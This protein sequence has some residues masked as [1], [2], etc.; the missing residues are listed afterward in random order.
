MR[1]T[2][3]KIESN[4]ISISYDTQG[5]WKKYFTNEKEFWIEYKTNISDTPKSVAVIPLLG[6]VITFSWLFDGEIIVDELDEDFY[7]C[8]PE[9]KKGYKKMYP[10]VNFAGKLTV[11]KIVKNNTKKSQS[12]T[13]FSGG[14]DAFC[15][16]LSNIDKNPILVTVWGADV[17][18]D[19]YE[20]WEKVQEQTVKTAEQFGLD[21]EIIR[22][23]FRCILSESLL[24]SECLKKSGDGWWHGFH[25]GIGILTL[26]APF[27][28]L[29]SISNLYIASSFTAA[30]WGNYTCSSDPVT[31]NMTRFCD[32]QVFHDGYE[33]SRTE[34]IKIICDYAKKN[35]IKVPLRVC[36][37][38]K[39]GGNCCDCEKCHRTM[40]AI[41]SNKFDPKDFGFN[42]NQKDISILF[43]KLKYFELKMIRY[44]KIQ[45]NL[46]N[47]YKYQEVAKSLK[48]FYKANFNN[49]STYQH[50]TSKRSIN[51]TKSLIYSKFPK[52]FKKLYDKLK[53]N[54]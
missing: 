16:L 38:S 10:N 43:E 37:K 30:E 21:Y 17:T 33:Y 23:N 40:L 42:Y 49:I 4:K 51:E 1:I 9:V 13:L 7:N 5:E 47:N 25:H 27:T 35:D 2:D 44:R 8:L 46:K 12:A 50:K 24:H 36:W 48:W 28:Y 34:K 29:N 32:C 18:Y 22:S 11:K 45:E 3:V 31:D 20:G 52:G 15:T 26:T 41:Y 39:D 19:N 6:T 53:G 54:C 14:V